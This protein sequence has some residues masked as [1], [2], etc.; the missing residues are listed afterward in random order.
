MENKADLTQVLKQN[1]KNFFKTE[2]NKQG[3]VPLAPFIRRDTPTP[4]ADTKKQNEK[5]TG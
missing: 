2:E 4:L 3:K 5:K 1:E